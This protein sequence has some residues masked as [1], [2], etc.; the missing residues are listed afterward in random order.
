MLIAHQFIGGKRD[1][2]TFPSR[3][4]RLKKVCAGLK[5]FI[6]PLRDWRLV[7]YFYPAMNRWAIFICP[8]GTNLVVSYGETLLL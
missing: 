4:G 3:Q 6:R 7:L 2:P 8:S 5:F 1:H